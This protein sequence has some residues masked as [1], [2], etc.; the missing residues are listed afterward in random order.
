MVVKLGD[1][2]NR[3]MCTY[4]YVLLCEAACYEVVVNDIHVTHPGHVGGETADNLEGGGVKDVHLTGDVA[5]ADVLLRELEQAN[6]C[7]GGG[8]HERCFNVLIKGGILISGVTYI[9]LGP[10][11]T[12]PVTCAVVRSTDVI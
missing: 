9:K 12:C 11:L 10:V 3:L 1:N 7:I 6:S 2:Y 8:L 4:M 5:T